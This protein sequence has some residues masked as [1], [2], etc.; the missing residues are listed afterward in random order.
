VKEIS[1]SDWGILRGERIPRW[2]SKIGEKRTIRV[3]I[4]SWVGISIGA[5]HVNVKVE[6]AENMWWCE[7]ENAWV[8]IYED[9]ENGGY[10]LRAKVMT[11]EE[12]VK[13]AIAFVKTIA[14]PGRKNHT[15]FWDGPGKPRWAQ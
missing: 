4:N 3:E 7:E 13:T 11:D 5:K 8:R 12:A 15:V 2:P 9:A 14:G 10:E 1:T 6:E